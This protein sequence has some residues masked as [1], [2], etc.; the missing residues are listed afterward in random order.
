MTTLSFRVK[1]KINTH[2]IFQI[3]NYCLKCI[4]IVKIVLLSMFLQ[5][6]NKKKFFHFK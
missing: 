2:T 6:N 4:A 5:Y 1:A 3:S